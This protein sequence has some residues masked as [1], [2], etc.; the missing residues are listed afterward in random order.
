MRETYEAALIRWLKPGG[1]LLA[2]F[3]QKA[4]RGGP[5]YGCSLEAMRALFPDTR[6]IWPADESFVPCPH[7]SLNGKPELAG[8]LTR[9]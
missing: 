5:P 6:W 8:I 2:L 1:R 9:R 3:M 7:P 4:E